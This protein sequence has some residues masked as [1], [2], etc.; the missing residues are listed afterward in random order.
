MS[1]IDQKNYQAANRLSSNHR[2]GFTVPMMSRA[3]YGRMTH[4]RHFAY[5]PACLNEDSLT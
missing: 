2:Q 3:E 4:H 5:L 1:S